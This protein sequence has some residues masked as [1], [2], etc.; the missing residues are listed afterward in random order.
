[1]GFLVDN[2]TLEQVFP[3]ILWFSLV[4]FNPPV[5]HYLEK[6]KK[7]DHLSLHLNHRVAQYVL[8]VQCVRSVCCRALFH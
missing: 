2:V 1:V 5:V 4:S 6:L 7:T 8:G 3:R